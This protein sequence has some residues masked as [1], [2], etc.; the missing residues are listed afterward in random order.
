MKLNKQ[1]ILDA[2]KTISAPGEGGNMV[3]TGAVK[4]VITFGDELILQLTTQAF[5]RKNVR[6]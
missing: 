5:K 2:L 1:D 4:N 6:K 3:E